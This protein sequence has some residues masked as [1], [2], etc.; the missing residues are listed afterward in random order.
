MKLISL[1][2]EGKTHLDKTLP[3]LEREKAEVVCLLE[4]TND[5]VSFL[6]SHGYTVSFVPRC[7]K[8]YKGVNFVDGILLASV[9]P[10]AFSTHFY[11][12]PQEEIVEEKLDEKLQRNNT[13]RAIIVGTIT[14]EGKTYTICTTHFTWSPDGDIACLAQKVDM[15]E[16]LKIVQTL[17]PHIMCGD[18]NI[19][20]NYNSLY[21]LL[22]EVYIDNIPEFYT[23][24][25]D[26]LLH[27]MKDYPEK[28]H[29]LEKYMVDYLFSQSPYQLENVHL[30][31]GISDHAAVI[32]TILPLKNN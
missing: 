14:F 30:Q 19:P 9:H 21:P 1:N 27:R 4:A 18:F 3:F 8:E 17:P 29:L 20:R 31:F 32:A 24:S 16:F 22:R 6:E 5:Y 11:Y 2:V 12:K 25:L 15:E 13:P 10:I 23:T 7:I 28:K 26:P